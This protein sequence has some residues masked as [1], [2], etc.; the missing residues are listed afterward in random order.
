MPYRKTSFLII[1]A[2]CA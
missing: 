1:T 2:A